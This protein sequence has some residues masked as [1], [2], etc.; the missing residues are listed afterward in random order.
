MTC[1]PDVETY[2]RTV[3]ANMPGPRQARS[4]ILTE[5]RSG[6]LDAIDV[7]RSAGWSVQAAAEAAITEFGDPR[8]IADAFRPHLAMIQARRVALT[9]A[10]TGPLVGLLWAAAALASHIA[11]R[12]APPWQWPGAPPVSPAVFPAVGAA[13]LIVVS[14]ALATGSLSPSMR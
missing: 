7:R 5:L 9:L 8:Q 14:S 1:G 3:A 6:L 10:A 13:L 12:D 2:L 4:D 11:I